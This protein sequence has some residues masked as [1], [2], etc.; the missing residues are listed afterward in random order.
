MQIAEMSGV[1]AASAPVFANRQAKIRTRTTLSGDVIRTD[2]VK[3]SRAPGRLGGAQRSLE[4]PLDFWR[5][6]WDA[7]ARPARSVVARGIGDVARFLPPCESANRR[8][9]GRETPVQSH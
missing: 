2:R 7:E 8:P 3:Q 4:R 1:S 5:S 6:S 9:N